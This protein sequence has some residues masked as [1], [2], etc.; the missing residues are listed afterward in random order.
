MDA[1]TIAATSRPGRTPI[2][3]SALGRVLEGAAIGVA[4]VLEGA[5]VGVGRVLSRLCWEGAAVGV[6]RVL[7][8]A[9]VGVGRVLS[10]LCSEGALRSLNNLSEE[11]H[12]P[13]FL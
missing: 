6:A 13:P 9:A 1:I 7:E 12:H 8:G 2:S 4:R 5:A 10:R 11:L 3:N